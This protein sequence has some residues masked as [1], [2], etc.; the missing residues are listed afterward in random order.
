MPTVNPV[1]R[2]REQMNLRVPDPLQEILILKS[3]HVTLATYILNPSSLMD[4]CVVR[5]I[6][7]LAERF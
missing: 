4:F 5:Q 6:I 3:D 2:A 1:G 7:T